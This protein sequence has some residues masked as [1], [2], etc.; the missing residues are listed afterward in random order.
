MYKKYRKGI[1]CV[2]YSIEKPKGFLGNKIY[3]LLFHRRWH[4]KGWE[5]VKG[6][7][8]TKEKL[9]NTVKRELKEETGFRIQKIDRLSFK[10]KFIYDKKSQQDWKS[11]GFNFSLFACQV[12]KRKP[13]LDAEEHDKYKWC[14]YKQALKLLKWPNQKKSLRIVDKWLKTKSKDKR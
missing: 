1:F 6:G 13:K 7:K 9:N 2:V 5:F 8:K 10:G 3:Y 11:K 14:S 12:K 4:W